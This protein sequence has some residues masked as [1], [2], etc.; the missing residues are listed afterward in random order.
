MSSKT[1]CC[2]LPSVALHTEGREIEATLPSPECYESALLAAHSA[3]TPTRLQE[4][5]KWMGVQAWK[6][7]PRQRVLV[8]EVLAGHGQTRRVAERLGEVVITLGFVHGQDLSVP[9][10]I[11]FVLDIVRL[12]KPC[13]VFVSWPCTAFSTL[14]NLRL[15]KDPSSIE[16]LQEERNFAKRYLDLFFKCWREQTNT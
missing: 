8:V 16:A 11:G 3:L 5:Q 9:G 15:A 6:L 10:A 1:Q 4:L 13:H 7:R 14:Q 2:G 12:T